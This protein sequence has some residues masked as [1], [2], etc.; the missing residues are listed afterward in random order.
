[1]KPTVPIPWWLA[2][3]AALLSVLVLVP[4]YVVNLLLELWDAIA[5]ALRERR[6]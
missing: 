6:A 5:A 4:F 3:P 2:L 1:M